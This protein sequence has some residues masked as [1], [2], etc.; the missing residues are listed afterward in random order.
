MFMDEYGGCF[1][2]N[3]A[4]AMW[5]VVR[6]DELPRWI[7]ERPGTRPYA[8]WCFD[9]PERR[10]DGESEAAYLERHGLLTAGERRGPTA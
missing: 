5:N 3:G 4:A 6:G 10:P 8:W 7:K 2:N 9:A 1:A